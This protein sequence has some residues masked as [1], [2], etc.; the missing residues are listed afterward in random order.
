M[1]LSRSEGMVNS[2][3]PGRITVTRQ[4][5]SSSW[6]RW[7]R[8]EST[9]VGNLPAPD[10]EMRRAIQEF[11][12][13]GVNRAVARYFLSSTLRKEWIERRTKLLNVRHCPGAILQG[14]SRGVSHARGAEISLVRTGAG[15]CPP[16]RIQELASAFRAPAEWRWTGFLPGLLTVGGQDL[17]PIRHGFLPRDHR[18]STFRRL[19]REAPRALPAPNTSRPKCAETQRNA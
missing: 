18:V 6:L 7:I 19:D 1:Y 15:S 3:R 13:P 14:A 9:F 4:S 10:S 12:Y 2:T 5:P 8:Q 11:S 17:G 16:H